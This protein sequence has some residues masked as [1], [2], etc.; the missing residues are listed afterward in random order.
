MREVFLHLPPS[1]LCLLDQISSDD[2]GETTFVW[3]MRNYD[4][5][6]RTKRTSPATF[7]GA[8]VKIVE[9]SFLRFGPSRVALDCSQ[10]IS[11]FGGTITANSNKPWNPE[12]H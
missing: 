11:N 7:L 5:W 8:A 12:R 10:C 1:D 9:L 6:H 2:A 3:I 4:E